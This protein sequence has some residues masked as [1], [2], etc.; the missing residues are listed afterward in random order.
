MIELADQPIEKPSEEKKT[1]V[2]EE[3][4]KKV[5]KTHKKVAI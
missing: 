4:K 3:E 1:L 5:K 2:A